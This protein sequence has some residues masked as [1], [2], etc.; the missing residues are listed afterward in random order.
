MK[1]NNMKLKNVI[2]FMLLLAC[3]F[4]FSQCSKNQD[5]DLKTIQ[6]I[7]YGG[8]ESQV[9]WGEHLVQI[10]A[11]NDCHTPKKMSPEGPVP[12]MSL[13]LSG[14][15]SD[16]PAPEADRKE[17]ESKGLALTNT[18]TS[19]VG[20]WGISYAANLT[21][22]PTGIGNWTEA[23]FIKAIREG[24]FKGMDGTR[25]LMPPMP[26]DFYKYWTD[27]EIKAVFAYLKSVKPIKNIV[28]EYQAPVTSKK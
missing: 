18:L 8:F 24:K 2:Y 16:M 10:G 3:V 25:P 28:P 1:G 15:P 21:P 17:I 5:M 23:N 9:K 7:N 27:D 4:L 20:P 13:L 14:H 26:W 11:C 6:K 22:D 19:W 12:D